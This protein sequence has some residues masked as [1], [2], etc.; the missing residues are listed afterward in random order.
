MGALLSYDGVEER[1]FCAVARCCSTNFS[2]VRTGRSSRR[3]AN[4]VQLGDQSATAKALIT[5]P[6]TLLRTDKLIHGSAQSESASQRRRMND[7]RPPVLR[8]W[9]FGAGADT[10][11]HNAMSLKRC[12]RA[13]SGPRGL[14]SP[15]RRDEARSLA[16]DLC[17]GVLSVL[18]H[19]CVSIHCT[20]GW[21]ARSLT[22]GPGKA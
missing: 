19:A 5:V 10:A 2:E 14:H 21:A 6:R 13:Y 16:R 9:L 11:V 12:P 15:T 8:T 22:G 4:K 3:T 17:G 18:E 1:D 7:R 20:K